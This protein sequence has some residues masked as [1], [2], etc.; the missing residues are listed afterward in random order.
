MNK[1]P[2]ELYIKMRNVYLAI[3]Q[4]IVD[5]GEVQESDI[6]FMNLFKTEFEQNTNL[7]ED[8]DE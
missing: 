3:I 6:L 2:E 4:R 1:Y 5:T 8:F 7:R